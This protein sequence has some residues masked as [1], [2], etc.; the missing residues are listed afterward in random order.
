MT[1]NEKNTKI[2]NSWFSRL[3]RELLIFLVFLLISVALWFIQTF[4][5]AMSMSVDYN[6]N[7]INKPEAVVFTSD[8]PDKVSIRLSGRGFQLLRMLFSSQ[9]KEVDIDFNNMRNTGETVI[10]DSDLWKRAFDKVLPKGVNVNERSLQRLELFY[11]NASPK[12]VPLIFC[13]KVTPKR[14][15]VIADTVL[16]PH[17]VLV[18]APKSK[19][20]TLTAIKT[21][22]FDFGEVDRD[23]MADVQF[24]LPSGVKCEPSH[25]NAKIIV[26]MISEQTF[27]VP[28][29]AKNCPQDIVLKLFPSNA[30]VLCRGRISQLNTINED[31]FSIT[32]DY[33]S[34]KVGNNRCLVKLE[35]QP[36]NVDVHVSPDY[37]EYV[38]ESISVNDE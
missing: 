33:D 29:M 27:E 31:S 1:D 16:T 13:G 23:K 32:V 19:L 7:I 21:E 17:H 28:I 37:V 2:S 30:K 25:A 36:D 10:I 18:Y 38:I 6:L 24:A 4:K 9:T 35:Q 20:D 8:V 11:S 5:D 3:N 15:Y 22:A 26:D 14:E 12:I 34:V